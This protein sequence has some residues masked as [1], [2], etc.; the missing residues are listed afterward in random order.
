MIPHMSFRGAAVLAY[1]GA[2]GVSPPLA[3][4]NQDAHVEMTTYAYQASAIET[5]DLWL[6]LGLSDTP[7]THQF[8]GSRWYSKTALELMRDGAY[9]EDIGGR[10]LNHFFNPVHGSALSICSLV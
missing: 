5:T 7:S 3:A 10:P 4:Y 2:L 1:V 9:D 6:R 8:P